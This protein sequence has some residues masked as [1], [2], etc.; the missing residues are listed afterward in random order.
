MYKYNYELKKKIVVSYF[1]GIDRY[2]DLAELYN[3]LSSIEV[4]LLR[5]VVQTLG[6]TS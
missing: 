3:T 6:F 5:L 1:D 2:K 4:N